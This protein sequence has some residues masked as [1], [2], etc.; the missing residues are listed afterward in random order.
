MKFWFLMEPNKKLEIE[1]TKKKNKTTKTTTKPPQQEASPL[2]E[3]MI[4]IL[5]FII[6]NMREIR[7]VMEK[8][9]PLLQFLITNIKLSITQNISNSTKRQ[10]PR[11]RTQTSYALGPTT[12]V[13]QVL[14]SHGFDIHQPVSQL[15]STYCVAPCCPAEGCGWGNSG[16]ATDVYSVLP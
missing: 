7:T 3:M 10:V 16:Q 5:V 8:L 14:L 9:V 13:T 11:D 2:E 12:S 6:R 4:K 1:V 15:M